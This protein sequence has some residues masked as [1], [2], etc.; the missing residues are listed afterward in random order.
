MLTILNNLSGPV[1]DVPN[2]IYPVL[3]EFRFVGNKQ[4]AALEFLQCTLQLVFCVNIKMVG[5]FVQY[6]PVDI[7][8]HQLA[9]AYLGSLTAA[10]NENLTG[11]VLVSQTAACKCSTHLVVGQ[12]GILVPNIIESSILVLFAFLLLKIAGLQEFT[13][14]NLAADRRNDT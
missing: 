6:Q 14:L 9:Q 11:D 4:N 2:L 8:Q 10:E 12:A 7:L 1:F 3:V 5:R 13:Q